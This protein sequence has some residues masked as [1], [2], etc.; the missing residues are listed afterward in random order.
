[1]SRVST[2]SSLSW[3]E[4]ETEVLMLPRVTSAESISASSFLPYFSETL[5]L[6]MT[7]AAVIRTT[8]AAMIKMS[9]FFCAALSLVLR[10]SCF[11]MVPLS[12][13]EL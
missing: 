11:I 5:F 7:T 13:M 8:A 12:C 4:P 2:S 1:M 3:P 6:R 10:R 9:F